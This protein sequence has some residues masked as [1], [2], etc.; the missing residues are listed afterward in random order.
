M[1]HTRNLRIANTVIR[2][3][4]NSVAVHARDSLGAVHVREK[5][6]EP[7][8]REEEKIDLPDERS[9]ASSCGQIALD[10]CYVLRE[11]CPVFIV[12]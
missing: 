1:L 10:L 2:Y 6:H 11:S 9:L 5:I 4:Q 8:G 7:Y 3:Q 12:K